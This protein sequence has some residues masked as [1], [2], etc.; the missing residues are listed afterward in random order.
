MC[1][2][3]PPSRQGSVLGPYLILPVYRRPFYLVN[4]HGLYAC[5]PA[6]TTDLQTR[7]SVCVDDVASWM[8][9][10]RLQLNAAKTEYFGVARRT[11]SRNYRVTW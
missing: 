5:R 11:E 1:D 3:L 6:K 10:N 2:L 9:A 7:L 8:S 4:S